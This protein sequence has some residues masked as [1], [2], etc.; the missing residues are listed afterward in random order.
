MKLKLI[1]Q[2]LHMRVLIIA[3]SYSDIFHIYL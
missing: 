1:L 2:K 3:I